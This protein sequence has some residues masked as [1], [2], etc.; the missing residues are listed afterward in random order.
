MN[1]WRFRTAFAAIA[2]TLAVGCNKGT[3]SP[4]SDSFTAPSAVSAP[5]PVA[6]APTPNPTPP[7]GVQV[8]VL[9][10]TFDPDRCTLLTDPKYAGLTELVHKVKI[11]NN[12]GGGIYSR[13]AMFFSP[14]Q[15]CG[16]HAEN[17][18]SAEQ[19]V[20]GAKSLD[21]GA[22]GD[23]TYTF[24]IN[25]RM[26]GS[27]QFDDTWRGQVET[28]IIGKVINTGIDCPSCDAL[29]LRVTVT[30]SGLTRTVKVTFKGEKP[31]KKAKVSYGDGQSDEFAN[32]ESK[33]HTWP[34][35]DFTVT[36]TFENEAL[37]APCIKTDTVSN[38]EPENCEDVAVRFSFAEES[39]AAATVSAS[40]NVCFQGGWV[41]PGTGSLDFGDASNQ[42]VTNPFTQCHN[43]N[44][45]DSEQNLTAKLTVTRGQNVCPKTL[46]VRIPPRDKTCKDYTEPAITGDI[47][48]DVQATQVVFSSGNVGPAGGSFSPVLPQTVVRPNAGQPAGSFSTTYTLP[49]GPE[50]LRCST[51]KS[52][53]K[54]VPPKQDSCDN[55]QAPPITGSPNASTSATQVTVS[56]GSVAPPGGT[57]SPA[58]PFSVNRPPNGQPA[59]QWNLTYTLP[60][61]PSALQCTT[62]KDFSGPVPPKDPECDPSEFWDQSL[63]WNK[64]VI[65]ANVHVRGNGNW[66]LKLFA[67][68]HS[69][70]YP[71]DPDYTK[72]TDSKS[73]TCKG[74]GEL[75]VDYDW[76]DHPSRY[77]WAALYKNGTRVWLSQRV[78]KQT[79]ASAGSLDLSYVA[80][81][82]SDE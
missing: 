11:T 9:S 51:S 62:R 5:A 34:Y 32:G 46:P 22:S 80:E 69:S 27:Y 45:T 15:T 57:F 41:N 82:P 49:Y 17:P 81:T 39:V 54:P 13:P 79:E 64:N 16:A 72:D 29:D 42:S 50:N 36:A 68:S 74:Q 67:A 65:K 24:P 18:G 70:E 23:T 59:G 60:Y 52:F 53:T 33:S 75:K 47:A 40:Y 38:K 25:D 77:W 63:N 21:N 58:V 61:G 14:K 12:S 71:D 31:N 55:Y 10:S 26:C 78:D 76:K 7:A 4:D 20:T 66:E 44:Q 8:E 35:G 56:A 73:I 28:F 1:K 2:M 3:D 30:G 43:Y 19:N 48:S 6:T 37:P